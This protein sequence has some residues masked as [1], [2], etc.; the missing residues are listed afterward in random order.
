MTDRQTPEGRHV[1]EVRGGHRW[2]IDHPADCESPND[3]PV[4]RTVYSTGPGVIKGVPDGLY[5]V[6]VT[7]AG[8]GLLI[9]NRVDNDP[10]E[11]VR[12]EQARRT[13]R[14]VAGLEEWLQGWKLRRPP[15]TGRHPLA[16]SGFM[17]FVQQDPRVTYCYD[18]GGLWPCDAALS[19]HDCAYSR[20]CQDGGCGFRDVWKDN[21]PEIGEM[22]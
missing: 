11:D 15:C 20:L 17:L 4:A 10:P 19:L 7:G 16:F 8:D 14:L 12:L 9:G 6:T 21:R 18:C 22:A 5:E 3:C 1:L 13:E 2:A